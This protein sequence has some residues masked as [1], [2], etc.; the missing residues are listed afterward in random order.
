M[1]RNLR[2]FLGLVNFYHQFLNHGAA[3]LKALNDLLATP[4]GRKKELVWI[5]VPL[6]AFAA[7]KD[8]LA[9]TTLL[10]YPV[11]NAPTSLMT[12]SPTLLWVPYYSNLFKTNG[13]LSPIFPESSNQ[14]RRD[15][16][17]S[18]ENF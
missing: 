2:E 17:P 16:V 11:L 5:D 12:V 18:T 8:G 9:N 14:L 3:I 15:I 7:V 13:T 4:T 6:K 1:Q 10:L